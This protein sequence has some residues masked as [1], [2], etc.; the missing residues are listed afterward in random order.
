MLKIYMIR[1]YKQGSLMF[2]MCVQKGI[3]DITPR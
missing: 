3:K 2:T 1:V